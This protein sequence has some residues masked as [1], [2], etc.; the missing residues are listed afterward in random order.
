MTREPIDVMNLLAGKKQTTI[1]SEIPIGKIDPPD[2]QPR[3]NIENDTLPQLQES[4]SNHGLLQPIIVEQVGDRYKVVA[5]ERRFRAV[6]NLGWTNVPVRIVDNLDETKRIQIQ[7][8]ENLNRED[9]TPMEQS[10]AVMKLFEVTLG[11]SDP[12]KICNMLVDFGKDKS[13]LPIEHANTVLAITTSLSRSHMTIYRWIALLKLPEELQN[14]LDDPN[15]FFTPKHAGEILKLSDVK[16]QIEI[17]R[18][19]QNNKYSVGQTKEIIEKRSKPAIKSFSLYAK[20]LISTFQS[21]DFTSMSRETKSQYFS[22]IEKL[23]KELTVV[24]SQLNQDKMHE[25]DFIK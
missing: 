16:E 15:G 2:W 9:I 25:E 17:A 4:I 3:K 22:E 14:K 11:I 18:L 1:L 23:L 10:R 24:F 8:T 20:K 19:I 13:R 7:I 21:E 12:G 5:G 6:Q